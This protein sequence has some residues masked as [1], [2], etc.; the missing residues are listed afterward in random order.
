MY[1]YIHRY[2]PH[3]YIHTNLL[4][5]MF[6][7]SLGLNKFSKHS[8]ICVYICMYIYIYIIHIYKCIQKY[9]WARSWYFEACSNSVNT[10]HMYIHVCVHICIYVYILQHTN[11]YVSMLAISRGLNKFS[12]YCI[13][14]YVYVCG[15][16]IY[17]Y[18]HVYIYAYIHIYIYTYVYI[19]SIY[20]Y[21]YIHIYIYTYIHIYIYTYIPMYMYAVYTYI[22]TINIF[23]NIFV[24]SWGLNECSKCCIIICIYIHHILCT[25]W[26]TNIL[27][28]MLVVSWGLNTCSKFYMYT[29]MYIC[30]YYTYINMHT[31]YIQ[32]SRMFVIFWRR[33]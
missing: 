8:C 33:K 3:I 20:I 12:K 30:I 24:V 17:T 18:V 10:V 28:S 15:I 5:S 9:F 16:Y 23:V 4:L 2:H 19:C 27:L 21:T 29:F 22:H 26:H 11:I 1:E 6:V 14:T 13:C 7:I 31:F 25:H 32:S